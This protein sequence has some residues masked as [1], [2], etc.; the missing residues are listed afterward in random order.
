MK[1]PIEKFD[2]QCRDCSHLYF[3][4]KEPG[5][6]KDLPRCDW[7]ETIGDLETELRCMI[8]GKRCPARNVEDR[9][10]LTSRQLFEIIQENDS[11]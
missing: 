10:R 1:R 6:I 9:H 5:S 7:W 3:F 11:N 8:A 2:A 4:S